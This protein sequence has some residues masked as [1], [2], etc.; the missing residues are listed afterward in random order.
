M[1]NE[2]KNLIDRGALCGAAARPDLFA[3]YVK[4]EEETGYTMHMNRKSLKQIVAEA[5]LTA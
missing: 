1:T 4:M 5:A 3:R 2:I